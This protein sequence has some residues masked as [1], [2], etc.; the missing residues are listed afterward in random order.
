MILE[1]KSAPSTTFENDLLGLEKT[2]IE[3]RMATLP[4]LPERS[5]EWSAE[6]MAVIQRSIFYPLTVR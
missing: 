3:A 6:A 4:K 2:F 1:Q 5:P